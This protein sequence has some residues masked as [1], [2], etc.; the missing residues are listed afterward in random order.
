MNEKIEAR[1]PAF[2]TLFEL[3][4]WNR[5][6]KEKQWHCPLT[7]V[8]CK[9]ALLSLSLSFYSCFPVCFVLYL[10][11]KKKLRR[12]FL[13]NI[14]LILYAIVIF[15]WWYIPTHNTKTVLLITRNREQYIPDCSILFCLQRIWRVFFLISKL[16]SSFRR[17]I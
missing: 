9:N 3:E 7:Y 14:C 11:S 8:I 4:I 1:I 16:I 2:W 6:N 10:R 5:K 17:Y 12:H 15:F 13:D